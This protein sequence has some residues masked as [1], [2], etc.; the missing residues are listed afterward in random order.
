MCNEFNVERTSFDL[1][2]FQQIL[3][4]MDGYHVLPRERLTGNSRFE[5]EPWELPN[6]PNVSADIWKYHVGFAVDRG[7]VACWTP[8]QTAHHVDMVGNVSETITL[9]EQDPNV[10]SVLRPARLTYAGKEFIDNLKNPSVKDRALDA[11]R[12]WGLPVAMRVVTEAAKN[13]L[14]GR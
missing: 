9:Y 11:L 6:M 5:V 13:G 12:T 2:T 7:F 8:E 4:A 10:S 3:E 14:L 1:D